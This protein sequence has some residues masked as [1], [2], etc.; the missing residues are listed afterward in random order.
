MGPVLTCPVTYPPSHSTISLLGALGGICGES[1]GAKLGD[2]ESSSLLGHTISEGGSLQAPPPRIQ[3]ELLTAQAI[4]SLQEQKALADIPSA[5]RT[6]VYV[7]QWPV[8]PA[9]SRVE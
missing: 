2:L 9:R 7:L 8:R 3:Y 4:A 1:T 5:N 6:I